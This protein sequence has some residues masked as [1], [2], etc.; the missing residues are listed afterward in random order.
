MHAVVIVVVALAVLVALILGTLAAFGRRFRSHLRRH[1]GFTPPAVPPAPIEPIRYAS[2]ED[3]VLGEFR[4]TYDLESVAG[5]GSEMERLTRLLGWVHGLT[6][7]ARNPSRPNRM[8]GLHLAGLAIA[9]GKRFNC[10][11]YATVMND[12]CLALGFA[13]RIVHLWPHK[14][15][16]NESHVVTC[17]YSRDLAKWV[18]LDPDMCAYVADG[19]GV[20]LGVDEIR[21]RLVR[22]EPLRIANTIQLAYASWLGR[23]LL[24]R[25]YA[26]Y[27]SKNIF[28]YDAP[29]RS[30]PDY[31]TRKSGRVY[32]H[33][34]PDGYHDEWLATPRVTARGNTIHYLRDPE[35]FWRPP[36]TGPDGIA[37]DSVD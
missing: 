34:I 28:R 17:V 18:M 10:W 24:K 36:A 19:A 32:F 35:V 14:E 9:E 8:N 31:E 5:S 4:E 27:L 25:L 12:A 11:M 26:W 13:S 21:R 3:P 22:G 37:G 2:P 33:L 1:P 29:A 23:P 7:H 15:H 16:P 30:E 6:T 20:P